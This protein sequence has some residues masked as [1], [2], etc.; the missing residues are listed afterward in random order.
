M[1]IDDRA[2]A[3]SELGAFAPMPTSLACSYFAKGKSERSENINKIFKIE[4]SDIKIKPK[5]PSNIQKYNFKI[6][7]I[8]L[9]TREY[10]KFLRNVEQDFEYENIF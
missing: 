5:D 10:S 6:R 3:L 8:L 7:L 2:Y 4:V 1:K 9:L